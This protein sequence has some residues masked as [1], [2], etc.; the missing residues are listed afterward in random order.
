MDRDAILM[1]V[2]RDIDRRNK[3]DMKLY[4]SM[5]FAVIVIYTF[6]AFYRGLFFEGAENVRSFSIAIVGAGL[7]LA[8]MYVLA[9]RVN[10]HNRRDA[11]LMTDVCEYLESNVPDGESNRDIAFMRSQIPGTMGQFVLFILFFAAL[12]PAAFGALIYARGLTENADDLALRL[13]VVSFVL[14]LTIILININYP[15]LHEKR[16]IRFSDASVRVLESAGIAMKGY[17][18]VIGGRN[19]YFMAIL[20]I[21]TLGVFVVIWLCISM[22]DFN[23]HISEQWNYEDRLLTALVMLEVSQNPPAES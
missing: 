5:A 1:R 14:G 19:V 12:F 10:K 4:P 22:R 11:D 7:V 23:R 6:V 9:T 3:T 2:R 21:I 17:G 15:R 18:Q 8:L 13:I 16:F 20:S